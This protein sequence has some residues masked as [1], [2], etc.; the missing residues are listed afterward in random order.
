VSSGPHS[1]DKVIIGCW[2]SKKVAIRLM[3]M[4]EQA[5]TTRSA[6]MIDL[7]E[8]TVKQKYPRIKKVSLQ[9]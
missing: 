1:K 9:A 7:L 4:A 8:K 6:I 3:K 5:G 2:V